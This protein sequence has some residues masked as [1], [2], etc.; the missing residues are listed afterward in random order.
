MKKHYIRHRFGELTIIVL[1]EFFI[2]VI[3]S[4][5]EREVYLVTMIYF[6]LLLSISTGLWWLYFD[7]QEHST[8]A[9]Q[10]TRME[11]WVYIHY[12]LLAGITAYG[13]VGTKI[14]ALVPGEALSDP[15]RWIFCGALA[16]AVACTAVIEW[17]AREDSGA[18]SR[19]PQIL[20]RI[21]G[22]L[23]LLALAFFGA[24]L[25]V[26][27]FVAL[28]AGMIV[29]PVAFDISRRLRNPVTGQ[30]VNP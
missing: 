7:H 25:A 22:A 14:L 30:E 2:K 24:G 11:I 4:A 1:G 5:S 10:Q 8:L 16:V 12:P 21:F 6:I 13:V 26:P 28:V 27:L 15:K 23:V 18:M 9:K 29:I 20:L 17:T 19:P 3:S